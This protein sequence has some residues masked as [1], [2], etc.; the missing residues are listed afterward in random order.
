MKK[1]KLTIIISISAAVLLM[2]LGGGFYLLKNNNSNQRPGEDINVRGKMRKPDF[3]QP[4]RQ[5]DTRGVVKSIVG[6]EV[7]VLKIDTPTRGNNASS[8]TATT[9]KTKASLSGGGMPQGGGRMGGGMGGPGMEGSDTTRADMLAKLKEMSTGEET[10]VIP[11]G[12][13]MMKFD[14]TTG[15]REPVEATLA[16]ITTD[17]SITVWTSP[18]ATSTA[19]FVLIN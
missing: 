15:S 3:G 5:P 10:I 18:I 12:I 8:T 1:K 17:K 2:I 6:N 13:K 9:E 4:D 11:V 14:T 7:V 19:E 16:D